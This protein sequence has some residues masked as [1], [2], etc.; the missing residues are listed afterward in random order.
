MEEVE[1]RT[2]IEGKSMTGSETSH[3][4][5]TYQDSGDEIT[6]MYAVNGDILRE[7]GRLLKK[8]TGKDLHSWL[9]AKGC[10]LDSCDGPA[11]VR[12]FA[13]GTLAEEYYRDGKRHR[14]R[15]PAIVWHYA[16]GSTVEEYYRDGKKH[17]D[18]GSA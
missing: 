12:R 18:G 4:T 13:S 9:K 8:P 5:V 15:G 6:S 17:R 7:L 16:D 10:K 11:C 3:I 1:S 14:A 2:T